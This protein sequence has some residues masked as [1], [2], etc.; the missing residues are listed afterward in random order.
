[1]A[2]YRIEWKPSALRELKRI[3]RQAIPRIVQAA[4]RLAEDPFPT[5]VRKLRGAEHTYR[6]RVGEHRVV[7]ET[8]E[9]KRTVVIVRVRHRRDAYRR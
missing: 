5:G 8:V 9:A 4:E 6:L 7:Y 1:M 3:D 2:T